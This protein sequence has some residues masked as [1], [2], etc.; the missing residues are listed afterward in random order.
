MW[1]G[2]NGEGIR[3]FGGEESGEEFGEEFGIELVM[4][5][6]KSGAWMGAPGAHFCRRS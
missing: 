1:R 3:R 6:V 2:E 5:G 4:T